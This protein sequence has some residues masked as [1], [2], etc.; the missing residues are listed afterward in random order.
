MTTRFHN[1]DDVGWYSSAS[2]M[3]QLALQPTFGRLYLLS[4]I[5]LV[6]TAA[7]P[8]FELVSTICATAPSSII[9][10]LGRAISG[11]ASAGIWSGAFII[12]TWLVPFPPCALHISVVTSMYDV[13]GRLLGG[14]FTDSDNLTWRFCFGVNLRMEASFLI[15]L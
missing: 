15:I 9:F 7:L 14:V 5:K 1:M 10:I 4:N 8:V 12:C 11:A 2:L 13:A 3:T 6:Y